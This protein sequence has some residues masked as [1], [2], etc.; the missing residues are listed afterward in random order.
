MISRRRLLAGTLGSAAWIDA[1]A[2]VAK[3]RKLTQFDP[4][5]RHL[6][7]E[8]SLEQ[9][10]GQMTQPDQMFLKTIEDIDNYHLGSLLSG[11][12]SDPQS[13]NDLSAWTA[14]YDHFQSRALKTAQR[15]PLLY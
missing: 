2:A 13:G 14:L 15:I 9:K 7:S 12:A 5:A 11:G 6:V 8:M 1:A 3:P 10:I 4:P